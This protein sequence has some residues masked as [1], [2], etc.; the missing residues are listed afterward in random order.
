MTI[1]YVYPLSLESDKEYIMYSRILC[2]TVIGVEGVDINVEVD[3]SNGLP[4]F[5]MVGYLGSE[6]KEARERVRTA[7]KNAGF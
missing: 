4:V 1:C 3:V 5:E 7:L 6:V 2:G